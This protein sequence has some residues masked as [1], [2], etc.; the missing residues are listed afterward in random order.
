M[1]TY[2][3]NHGENLSGIIFDYYGK[4]NSVLL[5]DVL[6]ANQNLAD[7]PTVFPPNTQIILPDIDEDADIPV[8]TLWD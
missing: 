1:R 2:F 6:D 7:I 3:T 5:R 4:I 8:A